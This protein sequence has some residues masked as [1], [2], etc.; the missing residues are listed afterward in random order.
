MR[1]QQNKIKKTERKKPKQQ[2][3]E[4]KIKKCSAIESKKEENSE[5]FLITYVRVW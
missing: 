1:R 2:Q 3:D 5:S 4:S